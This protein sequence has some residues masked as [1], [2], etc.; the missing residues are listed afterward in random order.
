MKKILLLLANGF[1]ASEASA[2]T[3][4]LGWNKLEGDGATQVITAGLRDRLAC[5]WNFTVLPE[6][7]VQDL[8]LE[9]FDALAIP[10]GFE[11]TGYLVDA[12]HEEFLQV[13]RYFHEQKKP[14]ASVC[15]GA[16]PLGKSSILSG[17]K[18]TTYSHPSSK[19]TE[20]L[21]EYGAVI[22]QGPVVQDGH[23]ITCA[24]PSN[25]FDVAF[26]LLEKLTDSANTAKVKNLMGFA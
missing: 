26:L 23:L 17:R 5:T 20:Q 10:G 4:V 24:Y 15:M 6:E 19:R 22:E 7:I 25:A 16:L 14:I 21:Q 1:E 8:Q 3:D 12:F 11:E 2:F 18:A 13:I 9:E